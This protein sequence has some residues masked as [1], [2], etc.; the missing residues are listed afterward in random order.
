MGPLFR[1]ALTLRCC[2]LSAT[3]DLSLLSPC[4]LLRLGSLRSQQASLWAS[5]C[6]YPIHPAPS[7]IT[8]TT[9]QLCMV[10]P[11][12]SHVFI[13]SHQRGPTSQGPLTLYIPLHSLCWAEHSSPTFEISSHQPLYPPQRDE[14]V[15]HSCHLCYLSCLS[16]A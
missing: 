15:L 14:T 2:R 12:C 6:F 10:R 7:L 16:R 3:S 8:Q 13:G 1:A 5:S 11:P 4:S 9:T